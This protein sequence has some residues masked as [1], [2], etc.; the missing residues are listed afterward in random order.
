[1]ETTGLSSGAFPNREAAGFTR[2]CGWRQRDT[3]LFRQT[4]RSALFGDVC[5]GHPDSVVVAR[6][7]ATPSDFA[8][9]LVGTSGG[10]PGLCRGAPR[11]IA[12]SR[13]AYPR[14]HVVVVGSPDYVA[15][16]EDDLVAA[17]RGAA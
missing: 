8:P 6:R 17:I 9:T 3:V 10:M 11:T 15:A 1:M 7:E 12:E 14:A 16:M 2:T 13:P 5:G 4:P